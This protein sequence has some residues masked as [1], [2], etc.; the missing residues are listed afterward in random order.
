MARCTGVP[1]G[2]VKGLNDVDAYRLVENSVSEAMS[3]VIG[4]IA[5]SLI[6]PEI[7]NDRLTTYNMSTP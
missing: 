4:P 2:L 1:L 5:R 7:L 3:A 6:D